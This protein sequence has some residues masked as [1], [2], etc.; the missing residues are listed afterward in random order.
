[1][2]DLNG[3]VALITGAG[4]GIGCAM[5]AAFVAAGA[6]VFAVDRSGEALEA[7]RAGVATPEA[8]DTLEA[9]VTDPAAIAAMLAGAQARFGP[10]DIVCNNAGILDRM[11]PLDETD[12]AMWGRVLGVNLT[13]PMRLT[14]AALPDMLARG[15][16]V[17]VNT[18]SIASFQGGRGGVSYTVSK[19]GLLGLTRAVAAT[20]G[21]RGIRCN[22]IA[23]GSVKTDLAAGAPPSDAGWE[24]RKKGLATRPPQAGG[25]DIAPVALFLASEDARYLNG[26][27]IVADAGWTV[28]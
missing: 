1:M 28:Y 22:A 15:R 6:R 2:T 24:L 8:L 14:R 9:D 16:G 20:Y 4:A 18:C 25:D 17:F 13:A 23:P 5:V 26:A 27:L 11:M 3:Q 7:L 12:D 19:H 10:V 21:A